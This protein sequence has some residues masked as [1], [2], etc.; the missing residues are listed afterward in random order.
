MGGDSAGGVEVFGDVA[1][2]VVGRV[3]DAHIRPGVELRG[4]QAADAARALGGAAE[5]GAQR[6][7]ARK[8][9]EAPVYSAMRFQPS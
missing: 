2:A 3:I 1:V 6:K 5:V 8:V 7:E 9:R 4:E